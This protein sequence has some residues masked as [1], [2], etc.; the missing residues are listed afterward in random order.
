MHEDRYAG[1]QAVRSWMMN[2][3]SGICLVFYVVMSLS[4]RADNSAIEDASLR[5]VSLG[6]YNS[7]AKDSSFSKFKEIDCKVIGRSIGKVGSDLLVFATTEDA[8][9]WGANIGPI[10]LVLTGGGKDRLVLSSGGYGISAAKICKADRVVISSSLGGR[11]ILKRFLYRGDKY[12]SAP[13][14]QAGCD[15]R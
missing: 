2:L 11:A 5:D 8:C 6:V 1:N 15:P 4:A 14:V 12:V 7:I 3:S 9:G 10:W 13:H